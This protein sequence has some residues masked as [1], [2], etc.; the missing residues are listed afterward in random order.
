MAWAVSHSGICHNSRKN[1]ALRLLAGLAVASDKWSMERLLWLQIAD[2]RQEGGDSRGA[3][4][5]RQKAARL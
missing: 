5:A 2:I 1:L 3:Q 4:E